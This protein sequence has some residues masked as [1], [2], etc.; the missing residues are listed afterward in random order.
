MAQ[1]QLFFWQTKFDAEGESA[2][3]GAKRSNY[4]LFRVVILPHESAFLFGVLIPRRR[5]SNRR[6]RQSRLFERSCRHVDAHSYQ[7]I[8]FQPESKRSHESLGRL[9]H[10]RA[11]ISCGIDHLIPSRTG[12]ISLWISCEVHTDDTKP[13]T[14]CSEVRTFSC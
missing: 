12:S 10:P 3:K 2:K 9:T 5:T 14:I 13:A 4:P 11:P 7:L 6:R 1:G 8:S